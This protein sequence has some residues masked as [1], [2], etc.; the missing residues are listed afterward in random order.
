MEVDFMSDSLAQIIADYELFD[1]EVVALIDT[2]KSIK[3]FFIE[4]SNLKSDPN[5]FE[6]NETR[7]L[8]VI[9]LAQTHNKQ[10]S[11]EQ[12]C[13]IA[14]IPIDKHRTLRRKLQKALGKDNFLVAETIND[15]PLTKGFGKGRSKVGDGQR[16][17]RKPISYKMNPIV[18][19]TIND[20]EF[21]KRY[22]EIGNRLCKIVY[23]EPEMIEILN[24]IKQNKEEIQKFF[25]ELSEHFQKNIIE[26]LSQNC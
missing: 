15:K 10:L 5:L 20:K 22:K 12:I 19:E 23:Q 17:G 13:E 26:P 6:P 21:Q 11:F 3:Q 25:I 18:L 14:K 24:R 16:T 7:A 8:I 2:Y 9:Y 1:N 4:L